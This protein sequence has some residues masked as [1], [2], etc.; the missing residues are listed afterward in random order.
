MKRKGNDM[1]FVWKM[2]YSV[3]FGL[4]HM[5]AIMAV[6]FG[7]FAVCAAANVLNSGE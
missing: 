1:G 2:I 5:F 7:K 4:M 6:G 3:C